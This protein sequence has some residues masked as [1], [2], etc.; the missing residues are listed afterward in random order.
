GQGL[1]QNQP[2]NARQVGGAKSSLL[3]NAA[4]DPQAFVMAKFAGQ[5]L[6][7]GSRTMQDAGFKLGNV[8]VAIP[9]AVEGATVEGPVAAPPQPTPASIIVSQNPAAGQKV[10]AGGVVDFEVR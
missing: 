1:A 9:T 8:T 5:P 3:V 2:A 6:G 10:V 7:S 4:A